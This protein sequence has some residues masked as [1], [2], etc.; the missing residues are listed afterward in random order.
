MSLDDALTYLPPIF[1]AIIFGAL[2]LIV[3]QSKPRTR[4]QRIFQIYLLAMFFWSV[5]AFMTLSGW[6]EVLVWFRIMTAA[7]VLMT[8]SIFYFV[9]TLFGLRRSW[10]PLVFTFGLCVV[11]ISLFTPFLIK[12]ATLEAGKLH[13]EFGPLLY[14]EAILGYGLNFFNVVE[15]ANGYF[16]TSDANQRNRLL[17]L[18]LAL[19][20][21]VLATLINFTEWGKYPIDIAANAIAALLIA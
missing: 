2:E 7:P 6:V 13:Y 12:T 10:A 16:K 8:V 11:P 19:S 3:A 1:S 18:L 4:L 14:F 21:T 5:S 20:I 15:L 17:Y 9:E